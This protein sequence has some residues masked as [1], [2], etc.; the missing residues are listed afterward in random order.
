MMPLL[1]SAQFAIPNI[2]TN[3]LNNNLDQAINTNLAEDPL[4]DGAFWV[5]NDGTNSVDNIIGSDQDES[6]GSFANAKN[7]IINILNIII[8]YS[9]GILALIALIYLI[10]HGI[11]ML[12]AAGDEERYNTGLKGLKYAVIALIGIGLSWFIISLIFYIIDFIIS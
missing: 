4:R 12:T 7:R 5:I 3:I 6:I 8:N 2:D 10:Y 11:L 1:G 9:L